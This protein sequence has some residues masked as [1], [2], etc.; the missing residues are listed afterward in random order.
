MGWRDFC[1]WRHSFPRTKLLS[2]RGCVYMSENIDRQTERERKRER[3][4]RCRWTAPGV[5]TLLKLW[6]HKT[7]VSPR[8]MLQLWLPFANNSFLYLSSSFLSSPLPSDSF[9]L[10]FPPFEPSRIHLSYFAL[11][12]PSIHPSPIVSPILLFFSFVYPRFVIPVEPLFIFLI[13]QADF[14]SFFFSFRAF[15]FRLSSR[16][17]SPCVR[18][19]ETL[20]GC[21]A[22]RRSNVTFWKSWRF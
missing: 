6:Q 3:E 4:R 16:E 14:F 12:F 15:V 9:F 20:P 17:L 5:E 19:R 18:I 2:R 10:L 13:R 1:C 11:Y 21:V 7:F 22:T 8:I